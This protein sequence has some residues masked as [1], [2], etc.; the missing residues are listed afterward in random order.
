ML[1]SIILFKRDILEDT[2]IYLEN[3]LK[4]FDSHLKCGLSLIL[5]IGAPTELYNEVLKYEKE[6]SRDEVP[7][8]ICS[9]LSSAEVL[10][11]QLK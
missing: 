1:Q 5:S 9:S 6:W 11:H 4:C 3:S 2:K 10:C 7:K 8:Q